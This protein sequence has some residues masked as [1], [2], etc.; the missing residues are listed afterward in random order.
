MYKNFDVDIINEVIKKFILTL[1]NSYS[2]FVVYAN[3]DKFN[4]EKYSLKFEERPILDRWILSEL[5]QTISTVDKSLN[6]YDATR[7]GKEIE[8]F[9]N[10]LSNWYIR[11]SRR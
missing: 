6:N 2:F 3:I 10:K 9:V 11:R 4:P 7:G 5:N 1:W 8:Q